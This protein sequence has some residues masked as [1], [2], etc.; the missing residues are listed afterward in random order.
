M[1]HRDRAG[2]RRRLVLGGLLTAGLLTGA[3]A[4]APIVS[5]DEVGK[6][7]GEIVDLTPPASD[8][9]NALSLAE[10]SGDEASGVQVGTVDEATPTGE[11]VA[12][13]AEIE[14]FLNNLGPLPEGATD[15]ETEADS[16]ESG[17]STGS[18]SESTDSADVESGE[19]GDTNTDTDT[20]TDTNSADVDE[21]DIDSGDID[22]GDLGSDASTDGESLDEDSTDSDATDSDSVDADSID[23]DDLDSDDLDSDQ[24]EF[25]AKSSAKSGAKSGSKADIVIGRLTMEKVGEPRF[26][27]SDRIVTSV[28]CDGCPGSINE[29]RAMTVTVS[30]NVG[31]TVGAVQAGLGVQVGETYQVSAICG[32]TR[33]LQRGERLVAFA[34]YLRTDFRVLVGGR[35]VG[36]GQLF[37]PKGVD[38]R[39]Q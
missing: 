39:I 32:P 7:D 13:E 27:T 21:G 24:S 12:S 14:E 38:C 3:L 23:S 20:D 31:V 6:A 1:L 22:E 8:E 17:E 25:G 5:A 35:E 16:G 34:T 15:E 19:E 4:V 30:A 10:P 29:T 18:D 9:D 11:L 2:S 37:E 26:V 33:N 28:G 36:T